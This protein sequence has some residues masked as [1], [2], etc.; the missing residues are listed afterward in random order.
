M[1]MVGKG[2]PPPAPIPKGSVVGKTKAGKPIDLGD[3]KNESLFGGDL[4]L[5]EDCGCGCN[6][7][8]GGCSK[9]KSK[10][11]IDEFGYWT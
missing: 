10:K 8:K 1:R 11:D 4:Y 7:K 5:W 3:G 2:G 6:G 9:G